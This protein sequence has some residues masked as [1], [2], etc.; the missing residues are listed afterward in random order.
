MTFD[1]QAG[2]HDFDLITKSC[3]RCKISREKFEEEGEPRCT[4]AS[5]REAREPQYPL[6]DDLETSG[7]SGR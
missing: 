2:G 1:R 4:G 3:T 5:P 7:R 6:P